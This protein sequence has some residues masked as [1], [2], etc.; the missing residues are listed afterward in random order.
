MCQR[1]PDNVKAM[2]AIVMSDLDK[3]TKVAKLV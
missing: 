3:G 2:F 1:K